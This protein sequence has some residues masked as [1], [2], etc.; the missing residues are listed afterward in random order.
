MFETFREQASTYF[1]YI[2]EAHAV[3]QW[4]TDSND[5]AGIRVLQHTTLED[6]VA[7][8][9]AGAQRLGLSMPVLV[10]GMENA[11]SEAFAAWPERIYVIG[12]DGRIAFKGGP[13]P[14]EFDP[15]AAGRALGEIVR[16]D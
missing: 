4:Q 11:V 5:E 8:A 14:W 2:A 9:L 15:E 1:V 12:A 13:G 6:R 10:D 16:M 7:E 3:D